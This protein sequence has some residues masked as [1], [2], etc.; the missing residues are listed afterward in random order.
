MFSNLAASL[1]GFEREPRSRGARL[2]FFAA[3]TLLA[4]AAV[5][6]MIWNGSLL[7][8]FLRDSGDS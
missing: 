8:C 7:T 4:G 2:M 5:N 1:P 6:S 3:T